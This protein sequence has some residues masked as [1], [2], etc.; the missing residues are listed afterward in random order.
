MEQILQMFA[1]LKGQM[2]GLATQQSVADLIKQV[3]QDRT[4]WKANHDKL[5]TLSEDNGQLAGEFLETKGLVEG[6]LQWIRMDL[7]QNAETMKRNAEILSRTRAT[8]DEQTHRLD[9]HD[10][11]L[12]YQ[13]NASFFGL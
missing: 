5:T 6:S 9:S 3:K 13:Q 2:D 4:L 8:V 11:K 7:D 12:Q 1:E 10:T